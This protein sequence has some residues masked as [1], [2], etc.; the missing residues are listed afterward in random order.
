MSVTLGWSSIEGHSVSPSDISETALAMD[1]FKADTEEDH[2]LRMELG[3]LRAA[4]ER[5]MLAFGEE[6]SLKIAEEHQNV[7]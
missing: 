3:E 5:D 6:A 2:S 7:A 4:I 1:D